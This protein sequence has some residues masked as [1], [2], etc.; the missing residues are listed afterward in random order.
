MALFDTAR[1]RAHRKAWARDVGGEPLWTCC[2]GLLG[3]AGVPSRNQR[4][5]GRRSRRSVRTHSAQRPRKCQP[6]ASGDG[7]R[8]AIKATTL[9]TAETCFA[10]V[11]YG[12]AP[13]SCSPPT[14]FSVS[15]P[16]FQV[17]RG[18]RNL[19]MRTAR[20]NTSSAIRDVLHY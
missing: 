11:I 6:C 2:L 12:C 14:I 9:I 13:Y 3:S 7:S 20:L 5:V 18:N 4:C 1:V 8:L 10:S 15:R 17:L 19:S 16:L